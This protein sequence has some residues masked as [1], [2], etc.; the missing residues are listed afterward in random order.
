MRRTHPARVHVLAITDSL[1]TGGAEQIVL[2]LNLALDPERFQ[3]TVCVSRDPTYLDPSGE[4]DTPG[5]L[6]CLRDHGVALVMLR[7][8]SSFNVLEWL[9]LIRFIR[10]HRVDVIHTHK[11][12][13]N[14]WGAVVG[15]LARVPVV[16][17]HEHTWSFEGQPLRR[18]IDRRVIGRLADAVIAV[19]AADRRRMIE[20]VGIPADRVVFI[21]NGIQP[22]S[23]GDGPALRREA[24]VPPRA[25][26]LVAVANLRPQK[27]LDVLLRAVSLV[28][29][30][31]PDAYLLLAGGGDRAPLEALAAEL[32]ISAAVVFLGMRFD[33]ENVLAAGDI[34]VSSSDF[35]G[36]P[37]AAMEYLAAGLPVVAT[38]VGGMPDLVRHGENG[39]LVPRRDPEA[40]AGAI[41]E[42]L[43]D[44]ARAREMGE[45]GRELQRK[46]FSLDAMVQRVQDL[47][48]ELLNGGQ[49]QCKPAS[50][51]P[52]EGRA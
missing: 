35:E 16:I 52:R 12:G 17:A 21:P 33:V 10:A 27:A 28:R 30:R 5:R 18:F 36:S 45:R 44:P 24:G 46:E 38:E 23:V 14:F 25:P 49:R 37:L 15:R 4:Y 32:G 13:S 40:L 47:Y 20:V 41:S 9:R 22:L 48:V 51:P 6:A 50:D 26:A 39:L 8:Q 31:F 7:R 3:R 2:S 43:G 42:L 11:F 34:A 19:S 1:G 29:R